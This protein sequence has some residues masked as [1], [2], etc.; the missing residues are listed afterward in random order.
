MDADSL[1]LVSPCWSESIW[2][3]CAGWF[4]SLAMSTLSLE[5]PGLSWNQ[6]YRTGGFEWP[7]TTKLQKPREWDD[8]KVSGNFRVP[9]FTSCLVRLLR[10]SIEYSS[11]SHAT[12]YIYI[13]IN[14][15]TYIYIYVHCGHQ[16]SKDNSA[17]RFKGCF[18]YHQKIPLYPCSCTALSPKCSILLAG[19]WYF[20]SPFHHKKETEICFDL[21]FRWV[22]RLFV[23]LVLLFQFLGFCLWKCQ[24]SIFGQ[25]LKLEDFPKSTNWWWVKHTLNIAGNTK[26]HNWCV[27]CAFSIH[28]SAKYLH[29]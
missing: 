29:Q 17:L 21:F 5:L 1:C 28:A 8:Q 24:A 16:D 7:Y 11:K 22:L 6:W 12:I 3:L 26:P 13:Y 4:T 10:S 9:H 18:C 14:I 19:Y 2:I 27:P 25:V 20:I 15:Y 23:P